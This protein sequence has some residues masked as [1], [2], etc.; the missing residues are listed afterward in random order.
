MDAGSIDLVAAWQ[1][2]T[3]PIRVR[4]AYWFSFLLAATLALCAFLIL[5]RRLA[6]ALHEPLSLIPIAAAAAIAALLAAGSRLPL[7]AILGAN[8]WAALSMGW[9]PAVLLA[10]FVGALSV[11]GTSAAAL[12]IAWSIVAVEELLAWR[13]FRIVARR[14]VV[15]AAPRS[16]QGTL[17]QLLTEPLEPRPRSPL[18]V[19]RVAALPAAA[20]P[21]LTPPTLAPPSAAFSSE[22]VQQSTR[23][24]LA[25]GTD[26]LSGWLQ[27]SLAT[28]ERNATAH[29]AFCPPFFETPRISL[30]QTAGP[31]GRIRAVQ[32]LPHGVRLELKLDFSPRQPQRVPVEFVAEARLG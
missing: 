23:S 4:L 29:I 13:R 12:A 22:V 21:P 3:A 20:P 15:P 24:R 6:G 18:A 14:R 2:A 16:L 1:H 26:R 10:I 31:A 17:D 30:R 28:G 27:M 19:S 32:I 5:G 8:R 9:L 25:N 7:S 11:P